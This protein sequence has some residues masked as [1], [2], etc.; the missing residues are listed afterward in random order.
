MSIST[1]FP[2]IKPSLL[3]DFAN[4]GALDPRITFTR[5]TTAT[6]YD[7]VTT[8]KAEENLLTYSQEF[9]NAA[10]TKSNVAISGTNTV[11][12]PDGTTTAE[13]VRDGAATAGHSLFQAY[14]VAAGTTYVLS[15]F[16][17][18]VDR[19]FAILAVSTGS[20]TWASA[21]FDLSAGTAGSTSAAG[22]GWSATSSSITSVGSGWY[23]CVLVFVAGNSASANARIGTATDGTTFTG[24]GS[25]LESYTGTDLKIASWGAQLER[26]TDARR[27]VGRLRLLGVVDGGRD[28]IGIGGPSLLVEMD[29]I[30]EEPVSVVR[31][32][33]VPVHD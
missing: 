18:N 31:R 20:G 10:W 25:G 13:E 11:V 4:V 6:Y 33:R 22:T 8:A 7:G 14:T 28:D 9:D 27:S 32:V 23:R 26:L 15:C 5:S 29:T 30:G 21:K 17:K 12:A 19:Q 3:L 24:G 16:L 2:T 1:N